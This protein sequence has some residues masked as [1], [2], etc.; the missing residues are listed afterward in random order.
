M[1]MLMLLLQSA[2]NDRGTWR[3]IIG[4]LMASALSSSSLIATTSKAEG[5][6][7]DGVEV[8]LFNFRRCENEQQLTKK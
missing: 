7:D 5:G 8:V 4:G 3:C 6:D 1:L 2:N